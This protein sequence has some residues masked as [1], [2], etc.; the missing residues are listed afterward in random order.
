MRGRNGLVMAVFAALVAGTA[1]IVYALRSAET[2]PNSAQAGQ[3]SPIELS[4]ASNEA[5]KQ[6]SEAV[7][8]A[9]APQ[10]PVPSG[11]APK[12]LDAPSAEPL[13][14]LPEAGADTGALY[15]LGLL[16]PEI[17]STL[18]DIVVAAQGGDIEAMRAVLEQNELKPMLSAEPVGDPIEFWKKHSVDGEGRDVLAAILNVFSSGFAIDG[19]GKTRNFVWP[20]LASMDLTKLT[21]AQEVDLYRI[22]PADQAL[23]MK[24]AGKYTYYRTAIGGDGVWHYFRGD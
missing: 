19:E 24:K 8:P 2:S 4:E 10:P 18:E 9:P 20:Y 1:V 14:H 23:A 13:P 7:K 17:K 3:A 15:D 11:E 22:V 16:P 6:G 21:P 5:A 12:P